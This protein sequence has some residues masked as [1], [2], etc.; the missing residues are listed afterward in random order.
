MTSEV[1]PIR[2]KS[3]PWMT[4]PLIERRIAMMPKTRFGALLPD[5]YV[6]HI[7]PRTCESGQ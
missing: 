4:M 7:V 5:A 3:S 2:S 6:D 1:E